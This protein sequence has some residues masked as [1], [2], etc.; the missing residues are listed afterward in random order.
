M[1]CIMHSHSQQKC[2][3]FIFVIPSIN[4]MS[5]TFNAVEKWFNNTHQLLLKI[6]TVDS[7]HKNW[8]KTNVDT[9]SSIDPILIKIVIHKK[10]WS[11]GNI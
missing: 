9:R 2:G 7:H 4:K 1:L 3:Q 8:T 11:S 10:S 5:K 6:T